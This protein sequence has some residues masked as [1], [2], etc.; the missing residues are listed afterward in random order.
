[1]APRLVRGLAEEKA[2]H[3]GAAHTGRQEGG[4]ISQGCRNR[5]ERSW[6]SYCHLLMRSSI[7]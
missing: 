2:G 7:C 3:C 5:I 1:M 4:V 6:P